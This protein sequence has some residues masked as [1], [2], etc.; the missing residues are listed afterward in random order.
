ME[1]EV[2]LGDIVLYQLSD[3]QQAKVLGNHGALKRKTVEEEFTPTGH[4]DGHRLV[5]AVVVAVWSQACVNLQAFVDAPS[6]TLYCL[7]AARGPH[8]CQ[9][10]PR[11]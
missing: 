5:P 2:K 1:P 3:E 4:G 6:G 7:S 11:T 9:W 10:L 8:V